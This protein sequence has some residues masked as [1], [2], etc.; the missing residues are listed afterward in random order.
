[1]TWHPILC[2]ISLISYNFAINPEDDQ[3]LNIEEK[4]FGVP[5]VPGMGVGNANDRND[6]YD[7]FHRDDFVPDRFNDIE[8]FDDRYNDNRDS[9]NNDFDESDLETP[10]K[11]LIDNLK[12]ELSRNQATLTIFRDRSSR[13]ST[14]VF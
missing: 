14:K 5:I 1:M 8:P 9:L 13:G 10:C 2:F 6:F 7:D 12:D 11:V 4:S 3:N